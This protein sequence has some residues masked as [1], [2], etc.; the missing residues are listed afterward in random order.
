LSRRERRRKKGLLLCLQFY[1]ALIDSLQ[2]VGQSGGKREKNL[3][4]AKANFFQI[5]TSAS[6]KYWVFLGNRFQTSLIFVSKSEGSNQPQSPT[7]FEDFA[8][9]GKRKNKQFEI[10]D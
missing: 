3:V 9:E 4:S 7:A 5:L 6:A 1:Q 8:E 2:I 10:V